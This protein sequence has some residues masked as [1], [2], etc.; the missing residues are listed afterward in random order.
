LWEIPNSF[1][2]INCIGII[3]GRNDEAIVRRSTKEVL[4]SVGWG[5]LVG[6]LDEIESSTIVGIQLFDE[7]G[8]LNFELLRLVS[9]HRNDR[10][11]KTYLD[12]TKCA[13]QA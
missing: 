13:W 8:E 2:N 11:S 10:H 3:I 4:I 7:R 12:T 9:R 5:D 1:N 6:T